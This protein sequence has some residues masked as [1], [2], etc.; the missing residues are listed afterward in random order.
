M[1]IAIHKREGSFSDHWITYCKKNGIPCKIVDAYASNIVELVNDC[2]AFM[3]HFHH[4]S[5]KDTLF[6]KKLL[7]SMQMSGKK[8]FPDFNSCWHFDDK[9][10]QKY[11][12]ESIDAPIIP[13]YV[14][15]SKNHAH[16]WS[17]QANFPK[18]FKLSG[19]SGGINVK[20]INSKK[21]C[22][23][24][25]NKSFGKGF[26]QYNWYWHF[27][28]AFSRY[29]IGRSTIKDVLRPVFYGLKR[30]PNEFSKYKGNEKGYV[31]F[32]DFI[33]NNDFDVRL[34]VIGGKYAY[35]MKRI[36][37]KGDFRA[38]GSE[39]YAYDS[40][41]KNTLQVVFKI[42]NKLNLQSVAF[43]IIYT[44]EN[45]PVIIEM[46]YGFGTKGSGKCPGYWD[47][48]LNWHEGEFNPFGWMVE[49][50]ISE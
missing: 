38:S 33:P 24:I 37:R 18:V 21:E 42:S 9:I 23:A 29:K 27:K 34:I 6:A 50:L 36:N 43:D 28:E 26:K 44:H 47:E 25:I 19:G 31:Y 48:K 10:G 32:Q 30:Y 7:F 35:G 45:H 3:W 11:L 13:T 14:F 17:E 22:L 49:N 39:N 8:V 4:D 2:N 1:K 16:R 5:Y 40:I 20:I 12:L 15:Y 41:D 46:S